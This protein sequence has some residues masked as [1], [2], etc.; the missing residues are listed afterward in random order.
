MARWGCSVLEL[1]CVKCNG[2]L[3]P[4][5]R[6]LVNGYALVPVL[7]KPGTNLYVHER[8]IRCLRIGRDDLR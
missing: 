4:T 1:R 7:R 6:G 8:P 3:S 5:G 2:I